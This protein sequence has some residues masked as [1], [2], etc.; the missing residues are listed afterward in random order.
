MEISFKTKKL[1]KVSGEFNKAKKEYGEVCAKKIIARLNELQAAENLRDIERLKFPGLHWLK[2]KRKG[3]AAVKLEN[4]RRL[5]IEPV[6]TESRDFRDIEKIII[7]E[8]IDYH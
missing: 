8:I 3:Q 2:G 6:G 7:V 4:P 5:I 1:R